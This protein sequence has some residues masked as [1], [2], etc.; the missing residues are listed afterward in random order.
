MP[1]GGRGRKW[2]RGAP[3]KGLDG[4]VTQAWPRVKNEAGGVMKQGPPLVSFHDERAVVPARRRV[5]TWTQADHR[6]ATSRVLGKLT[7]MAAGGPTVTKSHDESVL[8]RCLEI[9]ATSFGVN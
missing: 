5:L 7:E 3:W 1:D 4:Q 8:W 9:T 2:V 6:S